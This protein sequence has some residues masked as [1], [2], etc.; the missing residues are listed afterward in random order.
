[1]TR[2]VIEPADLRRGASTL[3]DTAL[4]YHGLAQ[5]LGALPMPEMP[6]G[7]AVRVQADVIEAAT[8]LGREMMPLFNEADE[9]EYRALWTEISGAAG[10]WPEGIGWL[11][12]N[13][14]WIKGTLGFFG[15]G[16]VLPAL[17]ATAHG[18]RLVHRGR[19]V[20]VRG[21]PFHGDS[22]LA[23]YVRTGRVDGTRYLATNPKVAKYL[24]VAP[25][26]A[27]RF[28]EML[29]VNSKFLKA[30]GK[31]SGPLAFGL[32]LGGDVYDYTAGPYA[33]KGLLS[34]DFAATATV[35][36]GLVGGTAAVGTAAGVGM[37]GVLAGGVAGASVGS[38]APVVGTVIG[39]GVGAAVAWGLSTEQG[40]GVRGKL[41]EGTKAGIEYGLRNPI[42]LG[43]VFAPPVVAGKLAYEYGDDAIR[44]VD[45]GLD[46]AGDV[47]GDAAGGARKLA[48]KIFG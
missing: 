15:P 37:T 42:V 3:R 39:F 47:V 19:Y 43:P 48:G 5:R 27:A 20:T 24:G 16:G 25:A 31:G 30:A 38:F 10:H 12:D 11:R 23:R 28:E 18:Y 32:T 13:G 8:T 2:I 46:K 9:L 26:L 40:K 6:P 22:L 21:R 7:V 34:T 44:A 1:M 41:I 36:V 33:Q 17:V 45:D 4:G 35:D 29:P 14:S